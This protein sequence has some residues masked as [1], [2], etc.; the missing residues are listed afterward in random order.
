MIYMHIWIQTLIQKCELLK[1]GDNSIKKKKK[2]KDLTK[3]NNSI[4]TERIEKIAMFR[5]NIHRR[6]KFF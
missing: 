4:E 3:S 2:T 1:L 5:K 6:L